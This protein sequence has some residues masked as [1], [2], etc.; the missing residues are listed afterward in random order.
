M[1]AKQVGVRWGVLAVAFG[2]L[3][4]GCATQDQVD[5]MA[6][7]LQQMRAQSMRREAELEVLTRRLGALQGELDRLGSGAE[8]AGQ[9]ESMP[10]LTESNDASHQ[11]TASRAGGVSG[12]W[13][14][15]DAKP[16][17]IAPQQGDEA[18]LRQLV[19]QLRQI[20][21]GQ[22][23]LTPSQQH[24]LLRALRP[25]RELDRENPWD[26]KIDRHTPWETASDVDVDVLAP[27]V[28]RGNPWH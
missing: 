13:G 3:G 4:T 10:R 9:N 26:Q 28:D 27:K 16:S 14:D 2:L 5:E 15:G 7:E 17:S 18:E 6:T 8:R 25:Q 20:V 12:P 24:L 1:R 22:G 21:H 23:A 11:S 19:R